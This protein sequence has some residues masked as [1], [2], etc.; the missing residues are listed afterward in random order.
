[1]K[2][3]SK[4][5]VLLLLF[6]LY[7]SSVV[8][9][10]LASSPK[11]SLPS[12]PDLSI[13]LTQ[14]K[15]YGVCTSSVSNEQS[16][17]LCEIDPL[18]GELTTYLP[19]YTS[20]VL[21]GQWV[22]QVSQSQGAFGSN[23]ML[24]QIENW[25]VYFLVSMPS[26]SDEITRLQY[27]TTMYLPVRSYRSWLSVF[28]LLPDQVSIVARFSDLIIGYSNNSGSYIIYLQARTTNT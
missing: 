19:L 23:S 2:A 21:A 12:H 8:S 5:S 26:Y 7:L 9:L 3:S 17:W 18:T 25:F 13:C 15:L 1:M 28:F 27:C 20:S 10:A 24:F 22:I 4:A 11:K 6:F 16:A 14:E